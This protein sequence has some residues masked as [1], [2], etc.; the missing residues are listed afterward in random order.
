MKRTYPG[1][2]KRQLESLVAAHI[3]VGDAKKRFFVLA[4]QTQDFAPMQQMT[5][6]LQM[7]QSARKTIAIDMEA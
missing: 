4:E 6:L 1:A 2:N 5:W 7:V 3:M